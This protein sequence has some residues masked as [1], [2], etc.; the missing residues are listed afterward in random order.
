MACVSRVTRSTY[1]TLQ[2]QQQHPCNLLI[3]PSPQP[4]S[5]RLRFQLREAT[6]DSSEGHRT[7]AHSP[8]A[9]FVAPR[10]HPDSLHLHTPHRDGSRRRCAQRPRSSRKRRCG[11]DRASIVD[12]RFGKP[13]LGALTALFLSARV[14]AAEHAAP[15][16]HK[17]RGP[18]NTFALQVELGVREHAPVCR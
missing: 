9:D 11:A 4:P 10:L 14:S 1:V 7:G 13:D 8:V 3:I 18:H 5:K 12:V 17:L 2:Q 6:E 16:P 15:L